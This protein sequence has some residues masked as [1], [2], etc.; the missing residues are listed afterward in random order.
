MEVSQLLYNSDDGA[1]AEEGESRPESAEKAV[2]DSEDEV[3]GFII[4]SIEI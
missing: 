1:D 2:G 4:F 3:C